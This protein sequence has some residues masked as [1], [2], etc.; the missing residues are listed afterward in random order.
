MCMVLDS[1]DIP[2]AQQSRIAWGRGYPSKGSDHS[3]QT[4]ISFLV[5][6]L[7]GL[8][9]GLASDIQEYLEKPKRVESMTVAR[10]MWMDAVQPFQRLA[11]E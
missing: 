4:S 6:G 5:H 1:K 8:R 2:H 7:P 11:P 9:S 3:I 10:L